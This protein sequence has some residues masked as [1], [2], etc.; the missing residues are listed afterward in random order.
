MISQF[1]LSTKGSQ[2]IKRFVKLLLILHRRVTL[3][4]LYACCVQSPGQRPLRRGKSSMS[5]GSKKAVDTSWSECRLCDPLLLR[6]IG[7]NDCADG[8]RDITKPITNSLSFGL[9]TL[10]LF[11][12]WY[13][14]LVC[15]RF[16]FITA[17]HVKA[18]RCSLNIC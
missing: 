14:T 17:A 16:V 10:F 7:G 18:E 11:I 6:E 4:F 5:H 2:I 3:V 15:V 1:L 8:A 9:D 12:S 13:L